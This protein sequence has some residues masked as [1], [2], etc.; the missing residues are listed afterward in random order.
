MSADLDS[1]KSTL[2]SMSIDKTLAALAKLEESTKGDGEEQGLARLVLIEELAELR[3]QLSKKYFSEIKSYAIPGMEQK[4]ITEIIYKV[5]FVDLLRIQLT[6][7]DAKSGD[8]N[9]RE[10]YQQAVDDYQGNSL[11]AIRWL[12]DKAPGATHPYEFRSLPN[13]S[14]QRDTSI[15]PTDSAPSPL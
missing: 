6:Q 9:D 13:C 12:E 1:F 2:D 14:S 8:E 7:G 10:A 5:A 4:T 11:A 3:S 15:T